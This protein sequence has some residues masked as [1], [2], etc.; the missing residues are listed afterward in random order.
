MTGWGWWSNG[1][2]ARSLDLTTWY[3]HNPESI[4]ENE[5]Q[6]II[7]DFGIK[8]D[9]QILAR[10]P[11]LLTGNKKKRTCWIVNFSVFADYRAKLKENKK[12]L[13]ENWKA[14]EQEMTVMPVIICAL[15]TFT[16]RFVQ[17]LEKFGN[18]RTSRDHPNYS[19][20]EIGKNTENNLEDLQS[21]RFRG[22]AIC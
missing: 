18:K 15:G 3:M 19:I 2:C 17:G 12:T 20:E 8:M 4:Q 7:W 22:K 13:R 6:K 14:M 16:K 9:H 10:R 21:L 1:N 5:T 11:D